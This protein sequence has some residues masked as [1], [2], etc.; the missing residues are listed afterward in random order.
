MHS[1]PEYPAFFICFL[2][3]CFRLFIAA[4][5]SPS[6]SLALSPHIPAPSHPPHSFSTPSTPG[7]PHSTS[8]THHVSAPQQTWI[9][10]VSLPSSRL[11]DFI[12]ANLNVSGSACTRVGRAQRRC[13]RTGQC[14]P[15]PGPGRAG[16]ELV[17][18]RVE[19]NKAIVLLL[20]TG[21]R[22]GC[23]RACVSLNLSAGLGSVVPLGRVACPRSGGVGRLGG[24][25]RVGC[26]HA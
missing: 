4:G 13:P 11:C 21:E 24:V 8:A 26:A 3:S 22:R 18:R 7:S 20:S 2:S 5:S 17:A 10:L 19:F 14:G 15:G 25:G 23:W 1:Y 16:A 12:S 9:G 6:I